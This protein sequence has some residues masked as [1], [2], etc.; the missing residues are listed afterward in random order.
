M[1]YV[2]SKG[3]VSDG[4]Q[5]TVEMMKTFKHLPSTAGNQQPAVILDWRFKTSR[6]V[7]HN[8]NQS[9]SLLF[10]WKKIKINLIL[11][12]QNKHVTY[13]IEHWLMS[14]EKEGNTVEQGPRLDS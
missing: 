12:E 4:S 10:M 2:R 14:D 11:M 1:V 9:K 3:K 5:C 7:T 13:I 8:V 6:T